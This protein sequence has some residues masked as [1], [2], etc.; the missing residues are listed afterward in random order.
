MNDKN[1]A[2]RHPVD[3]IM[4]E[5]SAVDTELIT[6]A[7]REAGLAAA[8]R[9]VE[10]EPALRAALDD[11][12]PD[13]ILSDWTLPDF[14]GRRAFAIAHERCPDV[15][16]IF[17]TGTISESTAFEALREGANDYVFKHQLDHVGPALTRALNEAGAQR[18]LRESESRLRTL[19]QTIPD[20]IWLKDTDGVYLLCNR[21]FERYFGAREADIAGKTDYDFVNRELADSFRDHDRQAMAAGKPSS[22]SEWVT[23]ADNGRRALLDTIKAPM[24]DDSGNLIGVMGIARDITE[25]HNLEQQLRHAQKMEAIGTLAGGIAHDFNNI[26]NV[27]LGY[28][29]MV[30]EGLRADQHLREKMNEVL[31]AADRA[32][33]LTKRLLM[34]SRK[35]DMEMKPVNVNDI[36]LGIEK[37]LCRIIGEDILFAIEL[38]GRDMNVLAD[39]GQVE[40]VLMNLITN[41]R[42]AMPHGGRLTISTGIKEVNSDVIANYEYDKTKTYALIS[43]A[44]TGEGV[45]SE[46]LKKIF[47][48]FFT[49]KG[50]G[51][52]TGLGLAIAYGIIKQH[53]GYIT[54]YSEPGQGTLFNIYL[55]L[56][57]DTAVSGKQTE[58]PVA[59]KGGSETILVAEDDATIRYLNRIV[60][61]SFGYTVITAEDGEDA[62]A[63]F[64]ENREKIQLSLIDIIMPKKNG[65]EVSDAIR[66]VSPLTKI[67]FTSG[68]AMD[69]ISSHGPIES[70]AEFIQ[71][72]I[73]PQELLKKVRDM[74]DR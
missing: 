65:K 62:I 50:V 71:K 54:V 33:N 45:D 48:P 9:R 34:F 44:D 70:G 30:L 67:L 43:V 73:R 12:M 51:K 15:P 19:L 58:A 49:T 11:R 2:Q 36:I 74:L 41:A 26:L 53:N 8:V 5:D 47:E 21:M 69:T 52:G 18:A 64:M 1:T 59:V 27:I 38:S 23:C 46:T 31:V 14:S 72:P 3:L 57:E 60:L 16:F 63:K 25:H 20:M 29:S 22:S 61:E 66:E 17:V 56:T 10:D 35:Q 4:V 42:D 55:P 68:Y 40:Q 37:M 6:D 28:G 7:L 13:A 24:F 39:S 32:T